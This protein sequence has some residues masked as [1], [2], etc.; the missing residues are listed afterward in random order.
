M[1]YLIFWIKIAA[2]RFLLLFKESPVIVIGAVFVIAA[3]AAAKN[4][5]AFTL[6]ARKSIIAVSFFILLSALLSLKK[7]SAKN[8]L[9][10]YSKSGLTNKSVHILYFLRRALVNNLFLFIFWLIILKGIL[11]MEYEKIM[12]AAVVFSVALSFLIMFLKNEYNKKNVIKNNVRIIK[13]NPFLKSTVHDYLTSDFLATAV[14]GIALFFVIL[15][16]YFK[17]KYSVSVTEDNTLFFT[18]MTAAL[19]LGFMG[20]ISSVPNINWKFQTIIF[21][22]NFSCH[23]RRT[24]IFLGIFFIIPV[25]FFVVTAA[26][27]DLLILIKYL[28]CIA[29]LFM[30]S[31]SVSFTISHVLI[32]GIKLTIAIGLIVWLSNL[33][34]AYL[35]IM[36][37]PMVIS[38]IKALNEYREWY[39]L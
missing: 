23:L 30:L 9:I 33:H 37:V 27:H 5:L 4:E 8:Q 39:Y 19:S 2:R 18:G 38:F 22:G 34:F 17:N 20:I 36:A 11:L 14:L 10:I 1:V 6:D 24:G 16:E 15:I 21:P 7:Y 28:Y 31:V 25:L 29:V 32:K 35:L 26:Y 3:I 12:P 13:L